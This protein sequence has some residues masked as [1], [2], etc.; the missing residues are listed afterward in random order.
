ME[1]WLNKH[2]LAGHL[3]CSERWLEYRLRDGLP[4]VVI[5]GRIKF[6]A[7]V[8]EAW[9]ERKGFLVRRGA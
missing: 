9:L 2:Q 7:S 3:G 5:A 1:P 4:C 8:V 6:R